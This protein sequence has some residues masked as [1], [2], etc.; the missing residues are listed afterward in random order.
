MTALTRRQRQLLVAI[1]QLARRGRAPTMD[2]LRAAI[3]WASTSTVFD[4][5][6]LLKRKGLVSWAPRCTRTITLAPDLFEHK[7]EIYRVTVLA[8]ESPVEGAA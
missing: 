8:D 5:L 7:G 6:T 1:G 3:G 2:E 4:F